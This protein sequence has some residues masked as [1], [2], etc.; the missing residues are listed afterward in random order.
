MLE[1]LRSIE[2]WFYRIPAMAYLR[3]LQA[4]L[5]AWNRWAGFLLNW[6]GHYVACVLI[7]GVGALVGWYF[8]SAWTGAA[9]GAS[10]ALLFYSIRE[11]GG[12]IKGKSHWWDHVGDI[13][14]PIICYFQ[15]W[16]MK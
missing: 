8:G 12:A 1:W 2:R 15:V 3:G 6:V 4:R 11:I 16:G 13:A 14:G 5:H 9:A 10:V 7:A